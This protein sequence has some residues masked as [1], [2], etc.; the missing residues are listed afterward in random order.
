MPVAGEAGL[1]RGNP[2]Q[3]PLPRPAPRAAARQHHAALGG[4]RLDPPADDRPGLHRVPDADPD[5]Q[6]SPE[7]ARDYLVPS[8][9]HPGQI[10]RAPAGAA[11]VQATDHGRR[12]RPLFPDRALLP[13]R[14]R[15]RRPLAG[16]ILPARFRDELRHAGRRVRRDRAGAG[17]RV[18][19]VR[20]RQV[21]HPGGR[22]PA[23][24]LQR[25]DAQI[26]Q[27][28]ARPA[29]SA[30]DPRRRRAFPRL[31]L[32]PVREA[33]SRRAGS[34]APLPRPARPT[35]AANSSTT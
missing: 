11:D 35:R 24:S 2:P 9:V 32:R 34:S 19:G 4:H 3:L 33:S 29:Q 10:L 21:G 18:R 22:V 16:R 28:Q 26:R 8:R 23:H 14:G 1:S 15:P 13:R 17:G 31:G 30:A 20:R 5:R 12:L 27:R 7:G 6:L 25:G